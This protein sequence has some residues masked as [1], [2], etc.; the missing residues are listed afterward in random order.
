MNKQKG[1][2]V[3]EVLIIIVIVGILAAI[4]AGAN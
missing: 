2:T 3:V 4:V 1:F